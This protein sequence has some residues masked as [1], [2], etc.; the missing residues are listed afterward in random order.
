M[1]C[2]GRLLTRLVLPPGARP[3]RMRV[4]PPLWGDTGLIRA[5]TRLLHVKPLP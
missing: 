2:A 5:A 4:L 3:V 1:D